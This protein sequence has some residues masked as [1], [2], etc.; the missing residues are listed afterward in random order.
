MQRNVGQS[1]EQGSDPEEGA[2]GMEMGEGRGATGPEEGAYRH[3]LVAASG[4]TGWEASGG[5]RGWGGGVGGKEL[6]DQG[7]CSCPGSGPIFTGV[8]MKTQIDKLGIKPLETKQPV[9]L[10]VCTCPLM[11]MALAATFERW[12]PLSHAWDFQCASLSASNAHGSEAH[13]GCR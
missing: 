8:E 4:R 5:A 10:M 13:E 7:R 1:E 2:L 6:R 3:P 9:L 11:P 12:P